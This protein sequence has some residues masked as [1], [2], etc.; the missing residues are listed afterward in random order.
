MIDQA[1]SLP[2][3]SL[4]VIGTVSLE[5]KSTF[6]LA[7]LLIA[8]TAAIIAWRRPAIRRL[9]LALIGI[10]LLS[11]AFAAGGLAWQQP[12]A[13]QVAIM[14]DLSPSTRTAQY[15]STETL[16][17]RIRQLLGNVPYHLV[18]FAETEQSS[19]PDG[20]TLP[21]LPANKT[22]FTPPN[23][24]AVLLFSDA[25]FELPTTA[26]PVYVAADPL[27]EDPPDASV[28]RLEIHDKT[29]SAAVVN[30]ST[31]M[32][33]LTFSPA[34]STEAQSIAPGSITSGH[35]LPPAGT[36]AAARLSGGD[37]WPENDA[38]AIR[39][40]PPLLSQRWW[41]GRTPPAGNWTPFEP[42]RLPD[43][44]AE[45][46]A[47]SIIVL[48]N[49]T[50]GD[51]SE[52]QQQRLGQYVRDLG[53]S[54]VLLGGDH[55]FAAGAY[56]GTLLETLS[57]L[58]S[59]PPTP[60]LHWILLGDSSGSMA[61]S[62]GG[63]SRWDQVTRAMLDLLPHLPPEDPVTLG[64][65]AENLRWW[66]TG[67]SARETAALPLP[68]ADVRPN[69]PTNLEDALLQTIS[70]A[71]STMPKELLL[72]T[73]ADAQ[74]TQLESI[75]Q[76]LIDKKIR[77]DLL[78]LRNDGRAL[79]Q[80]EELTRATGGQSLRELTPGKWTEAAQKLYAK[81]APDRLQ[82]QAATV[83]YAAQLSHLPA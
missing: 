40:P 34:D 75:R 39:I 64:S 53:G 8:I 42:G 21:D 44:S 56:P 38:L 9:S 78:A 32:R 30:Q 57:P 28:T 11:L 43:E 15:R 47:P 50:A 4:S 27:L 10:G 24:A 49:V 35:P 55:A 76:G 46:L 68:P 82:T 6:A 80:L 7:T 22:I 5:S 71:D 17:R 65:F 36:E 69:G 41:V 12:S 1:D 25:Q 63:P 48:D 70:S 3:S 79:R 77:L 54:I 2:L 59:T 52:L 18:Y 31:Q 33:E 61:S 60:T 19:I 16:H 58:S 67:K 66:S 73:D 81:A 20:P 23:A 72:L 51:L 29:L 83:R 26:P 14:V 62:N 13:Q 74:I 37:P 45:Y